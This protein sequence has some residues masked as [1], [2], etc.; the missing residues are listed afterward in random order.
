MKKINRLVCTVAASMLIVVSTA[1]AGMPLKVQ[2]SLIE[3]YATF[4]E[5]SQ[6]S[7]DSYEISLT[8]TKQG[9]KRKDGNGYSSDAP[10]MLMAKKRRRERK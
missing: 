4:W 1:I 3:S 6:S 2:P 7:V 9:L 5:Q 8:D 10:K